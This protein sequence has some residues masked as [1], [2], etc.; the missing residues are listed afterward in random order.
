MFD[1]TFSRTRCSPMNQQGDRVSESRSCLTSECMVTTAAAAV[2][3][4]AFFAC[5][6]RESSKSLYNRIRCFNVAGTCAGKVL[7][8]V[9]VYFLMPT[10]VQLHIEIKAAL[11]R[12]GKPVARPPVCSPLCLSVCL[13]ARVSML[14]EVLCATCLI[15]SPDQTQLQCI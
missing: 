1:G 4:R 15:H 2:A 3:N 11:I 6:T 7:S 5:E 14:Q 9:T 12:R 8:C 10:V 13:S